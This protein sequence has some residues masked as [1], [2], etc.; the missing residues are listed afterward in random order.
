MPTVRIKGANLTHIILERQE[1][2]ASFVREEQAE[3]LFQALIGN[4]PG[5]IFR[6]LVTKM[7]AYK[8]DRLLINGPPW[9]T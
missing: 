9:E 3:A 5:C 8:R 7:E 6:R 2:D 4:L 1:A